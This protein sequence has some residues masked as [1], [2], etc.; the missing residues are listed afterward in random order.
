[1][2]V[3]MLS[4][5]HYAHCDACR[6]DA[7]NDM[8]EPED[9]SKRHDTCDMSNSHHTCDLHMSEPTGVTLIKQAKD[10]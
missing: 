8:T 4:S 9:M 1:V 10:R 6:T 7:M 3:A 5:P 2:S